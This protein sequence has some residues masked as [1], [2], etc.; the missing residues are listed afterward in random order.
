MEQLPLDFSQPPNRLTAIADVE[1]KKNIV[2]N[3]YNQQGNSYSSTNPDALAD[4]DAM[5]RGTGVFLDV[6]NQSVGTSVDVVER[7]NEI[8]IN[9][10]QPN[11]PYNVRGEV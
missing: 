11:K 9:K 1:R 3:D 2:K 8:K 10:Y 5:G 6:Y 4:G 7:K